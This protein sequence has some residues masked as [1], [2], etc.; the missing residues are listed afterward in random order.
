MHQMQEYICPKKPDRLQMGRT[1]AEIHHCTSKGAQQHESPQL[2]FSPFQQ[3]QGSC[4]PYRQAK[5][6]VQHRCES[7]QPPPKRPQQVVHHTYRDPQQDR[8]QKQDQ[9]LGDLH[10]HLQPN[11]RPRNPLRACPSSS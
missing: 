10:L 2:T 11:R 7:G 4:G 6:S 3:K 8:L 5:G 9:L 1:A